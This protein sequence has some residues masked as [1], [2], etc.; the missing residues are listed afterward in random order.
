MSV[1]VPTLVKMPPLMGPVN[2]VLVLSDPIVAALKLNS[3]A[4]ESERWLVGKGESTRPPEAM[5][6]A[7][8]LV[9]V[10]KRYAPLPTPTGPV[11]L[12]GGL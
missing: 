3:P 11:R 9:K 4:P 1:P 6:S 12:T 7:P 5:V 2:T 8:P 10:A